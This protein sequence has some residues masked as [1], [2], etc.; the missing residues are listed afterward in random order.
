MSGQGQPTCSSHSNSAPPPS[1]LIPL[2]TPLKT[3]LQF[4]VMPLL[5]GRVGG[6]RRARRGGT[7]VGPD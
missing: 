4:G 7:W 3:M 1:Q 5:N 2:Q 6:M